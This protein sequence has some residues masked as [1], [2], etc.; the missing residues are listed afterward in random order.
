MRMKEKNRDQFL[1]V[2]NIEDYVCDLKYFCNVGLKFL[3]KYL[4]DHPNGV[5]ASQTGQFED[6]FPA[7]GGF[8]WAPPTV[9]SAE[10]NC[11]FN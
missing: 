8:F 10:F 9:K 6:E 2:E 3:Q 4:K 7:V 1:K 11:Q 5:R